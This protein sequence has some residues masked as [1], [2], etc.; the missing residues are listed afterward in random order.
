MKAHCK[1]CAAEVLVIG[2]RRLYHSGVP[3]AWDEEEVKVESV[4]PER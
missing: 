4:A 3:V 2:G 1:S